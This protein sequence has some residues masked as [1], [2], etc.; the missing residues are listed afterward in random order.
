M[1]KRMIFLILLISPLI[2]AS[3]LINQF[4]LFER[5][6]DILFLAF[7]NTFAASYLLTRELLAGA[8][9]KGFVAL[10][11]EFFTWGFTF[12]VTGLVTAITALSLSVTGFKHGLGELLNF[13]AQISLNL[14]IGGVTLIGAS[15]PIL[16]SLFGQGERKAEPSPPSSGESG[17]QQSNK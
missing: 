9:A 1:L 3:L 11:L 15:F 4:E 6:T 14:L 17:T 2:Y 7:A 13:Y 12:T 10:S 5:A 16:Q 8:K